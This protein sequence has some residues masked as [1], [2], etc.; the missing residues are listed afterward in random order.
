M[1]KQTIINYSFPSFGLSVMH[2]ASKLIRSEFFNLDEER[3]PLVG[4]ANELTAKIIAQLDEYVKNSQFVFSLPLAI[5]GTEHQKKVWQIMLG[6]KSGQTLSYGEVAREIGSAPRAVGGACGKNPLP[7]F[8]PC[9]RIVGSKLSL[10]GFNS[11]NIFFNLGIK[12]WLL[13]HEGIL[14][15]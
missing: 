11:G 13:A 1:D 2:A 5:A 8:I 6:L 10:G 7:V 9:H 12:Q 15:K 4:V 14:I 3:S